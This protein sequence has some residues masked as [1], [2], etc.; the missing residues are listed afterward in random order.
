VYFGRA[1]EMYRRALEQSPYQVFLRAELAYYFFSTKHNDLASGE[2][3]QILQMEPAYFNARLLL[4]EIKLRQG[5]R[6]GAQSELQELEQMEKRFATQKA[7]PSTSY[8]RSLLE[9]NVQKKS[10]LLRL[11]Q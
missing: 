7:S 4:A 10:E 5:D 3:T 8:I 9:L 2:L 11:V 1:V 6:A